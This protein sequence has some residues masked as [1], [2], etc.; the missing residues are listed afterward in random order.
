MRPLLY[1]L[2]AALAVA[3]RPRPADVAACDA[4]GDAAYAAH[5][6]SLHSVRTL[7]AK[8]LAAARAAGYGAGVAEAYNHKAFAHMA[9]MRYAEAQQCLDSA[10][11]STRNE[12]ELLVADVQR[13]RLCQRRS[14]N[15][16]FYRWRRSA[17]ERLARIDAWR[18]GEGDDAM[19]AHWRRRL[20]YARSERDI[21]ASTYFYYV[22]L[23][24]ASRQA[25]ADTDPEGD[26]KADTAQQMNWWYNRGAGGI[27]TPA[28]TGDAPD[29][30]TAEMECLMRCLLL[31]QR[32]RSTFW[33][34]NALQA[35]SEHIDN[36]DAAH[37]DFVRGIDP[38]V[39]TRRVPRAL[40]AGDLA[41]HALLLFDRYGDAYQ[42]AGAYR[43]LAQQYFAAGDYAAA[44]ACLNNAL[45]PAVQAAP[46]LVASIREQLSKAWAALDNKAESDR[47]RNAYLD[48]QE[49]TRQD[50]QLEARAEQM[51]ASARQQR[52]WM[53]GVAAMLL[54]L[55]VAAGMLMVRAWHWRKKQ[56][57]KR[58]D[59]QTPLRQWQTRRDTLSRQREE[60]AEEW[61]EHIAAAA[62]QRDAGQEQNAEQRARVALVAHTGVLIER[63][64]AETMR[65]D[66]TAANSLNDNAQQPDQQPEALSTPTT[67]NPHGNHSQPAADP[68]REYIA[69]IARHIGAN[70]STLT[71]WIA[72]RQGAVSL[73]IETFDVSPLL[74][75][76]RTGATRP[77]LT[78]HAAPCAVKAD[79]AMTLFMLNTLIDNARKHT[80]PEGEI[81]VQAAPCEGGVELSVADNGCGMDAEHVQHLFDRTALRPHASDTAAPHTGGWGFGLLNCRGII[82]S[83]RKLS[84]LFAVCQI[85]A[86]SQPGRGTRIAFRLPAGRALVVVAML[87]IGGLTGE[88]GVPACDTKSVEERTAGKSACPPS[89]TPEQWADSAYYSNLNAHYEQTLRHATRCME[90][91]NRLAPKGTPAMRLND[92]AD[93]TPAEQLWWQAGANLPYATILDIRNETAVAAL[94][95]HRWQLYDYNNRAY[96]A[97]LALVSADAT[98][99]DYV[100]AMQRARQ[101]RQMAIFLLVAM[102]PAVLFAFYMLYGRRYLAW[103]LRRER[104]AQTAQILAADDTPAQQA[105]AITRLW[106]EEHGQDPA[107]RQALN[108][109]VRAEAEDRDWHDTQ[110][111]AREQLRATEAQRDALHVANNIIDNGLSALKH[112]TLY[113]P[114]RLL[115]LLQDGAPAAE[116]RQTA[117]HY[118]ALYAMLATLV[119]RQT[120][121][122]LHIG[123]ALVQHLFRLLSAIG[124]DT[125]AATRL[126][127]PAPGYAVL[128]MPCP[129]ATPEWFA[130]DTADLRHAVCR[131]I[132]R[133][134]AEET[135]LH[136]CGITARDGQITLTLADRHLPQNT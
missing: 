47:N 41:Q 104:L 37:E 20:A 135:G 19:P 59:L 85:T 98:L 94:A 30:W 132:A 90:A 53:A 84:A 83:Y 60:E 88:A 105:E 26:I 65:L 124:A 45:T 122:P 54:A 97:L 35:I 131:Q 111:A 58:D 23:P 43:T 66:D 72:M 102:L 49:D 4:L 123:E 80:P 69:E 22:G 3:C 16:E 62:M 74:D 36:G 93:R 10:T 78:I 46:D 7:A 55:V 32:A 31:A 127:P 79:R 128:Q 70:N 86:Q 108:T 100:L 14:L 118:R 13:M 24:E 129:G 75:M 87:W 101:N 76:L 109:L 39:N 52:A 106:G 119:Q 68:R 117:E 81:T 77:R 56:P 27:I 71:R 61:Q 113:H 29:V 92:T 99:D 112:E 21:V 133:E 34:A 57:Q 8:Q 28:D 38:I 125:T 12:V 11:A 51:E 44:V 120:D 9:A 134:Q 2:L 121:K 63:L 96:T 17:E 82:D 115:R 1:F 50:R 5:Y 64:A 67:Y 91:L 136:R 18:E 48:I 33:E 103:R 110:T 25:L 107:L 40:L 89:Y 42:R 15:K 116:L 114:D 95:L 126:P 130:P 6:R 73:R